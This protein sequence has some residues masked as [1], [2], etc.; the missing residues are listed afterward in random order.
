MPDVNEIAYDGFEHGWNG[1]TG[2]WNFGWYHSGDSSIVSEGAY[3]GS[4]SL[5]LRNVDGYVDRQ[6]DL[7][8]YGTSKLTF[9]ARVDDFEGDDFAELKVK[10]K[11]KWNTIKTFTSA[12]SN[13]YQY[14]EFD[15]TPYRLTGGFWIAFDAEMSDSS[16]ALY[17]DELRII[18]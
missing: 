18:E 9:Y 12:D 6:L 13:N 15:L 11:G 3:L 5:R 17:I 4:N 2:P 8:A 10:G 7:S 14:Y 16:D 1:G